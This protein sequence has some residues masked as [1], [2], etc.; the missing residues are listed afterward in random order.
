M[1][2]KFPINFKNIGGSPK[3]SKIFGNLYQ[4]YNFKTMKIQIVS[5]ISDEI[6]K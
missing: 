2:G 4:N 1:F 6:S 5:E 3:I